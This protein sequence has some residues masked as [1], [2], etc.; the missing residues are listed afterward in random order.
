[1]KY[2]LIDVQYQTDEDVEF[3]TCELCFYTGSLTVEYW[4]LEDENGRKFTY[5]NGQWSWG[6][7]FHGYRIDNYIDFADVISKNEYPEY[8]EGYPEFKYRYENNLESI[9][10]EMYSDYDEWLDKKRGWDE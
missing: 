10:H 8:K 7:Y 4:V 3:G 6:D 5:E 9:V 1:M 2:K